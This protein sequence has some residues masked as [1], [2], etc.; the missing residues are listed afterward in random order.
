MIIY[1]KSIQ[2]ESMHNTIPFLSN[3][4]GR[5]VCVYVGVNE[6]QKDGQQKVTD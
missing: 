4:I 3:D 1:K 5:C 2:G 6:L